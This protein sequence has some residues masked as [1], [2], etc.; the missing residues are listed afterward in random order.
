MCECGHTTIAR[1]TTT[2]P[3]SGLRIASGLV[4]NDYRLEQR[5]EG[6][7]DYH[8]GGD[9]MGIVEDYS[10]RSL[11]NL[12]DRLSAISGIARLMLNATRANKPAFTKTNKPISEAYYAGLWA[13]SFLTDLAWTALKEPDSGRH[14]HRRPEQYRAP[15]WSWASIDGPVRL[16]YRDDVSVSKYKIVR[17]AL[18][19][20]AGCR[21]LSD[22]D[23][24]GRL[25]SGY[26]LLTG[27]LAAVEL[28]CLTCV[29]LLLAIL[30][31]TDIFLPG[32]K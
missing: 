19:R 16:A 26:A 27:P 28:V 29:S 2:G 32:K 7:L 10:S 23:P 21:T 9:W 5:E 13:S 30:F 17:H 24:T 6:S 11:T 22:A 3:L 18:V 15:T 14:I 20:E 8:P 4:W 12:Q 1:R 31:G 25:K